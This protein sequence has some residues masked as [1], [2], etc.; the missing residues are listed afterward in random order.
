MV[1]IRYLLFG[2]SILESIVTTAIKT[3]LVAFAHANLSSRY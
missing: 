1:R 3:D 2:K